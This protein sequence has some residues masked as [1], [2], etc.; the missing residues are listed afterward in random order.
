MLRT[1]AGFS[2]MEILGDLDKSDV[3]REM[4]EKVCLEFLKARA[5]ATSHSYL[6]VP[7]PPVS[8]TMPG[9]QQSVRKIC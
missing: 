3:G 1:I 5:D 8:T 9:P 2:N 7:P 4:G 6:C